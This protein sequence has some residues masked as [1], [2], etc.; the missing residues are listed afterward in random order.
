MIKSQVNERLM[1]LSNESLVIEPVQMDPPP[2]YDVEQFALSGLDD[3][4]VRRLFIRKVIH[5]RQ[6]MV[7]YKMTPSRDSVCFFNATLGLE[8]ET[9][10]SH[11][12]QI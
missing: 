6:Q 5:R 2:D 3:K 4:T 12:T 8:M 11:T 7:Y 9:R 10:I 1:C